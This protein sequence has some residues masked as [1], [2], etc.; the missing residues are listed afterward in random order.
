[1]P[2]NVSNP[3]CSFIQHAYLRADLRMECRLLLSVT[4]FSFS[5]R[6]QLLRQSA[7]AWHARHTG[8]PKNSEFLHY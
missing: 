3:A 5:E 8:R 1:M 7:R 6:A 4:T 2:L